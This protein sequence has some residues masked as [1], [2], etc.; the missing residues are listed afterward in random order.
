MRRDSPVT[1]RAMTLPFASFARGAAAVLLLALAACSAPATQQRFPELTY[2]HHG[3]INLDVARIEFNNAYLPPL[4]AP[5]VEHLAP[6][7][8][9]L[10]MERW[11]RD[12]LR[13]TGVTGEAR[14]VLRDAKIVE[15]KLAVQGGVKGMFTTDQGYRYDCSI[16]VEIQIRDANNVQRGFAKAQ[17]AR[18]R[19]V[20]E[21]ATLAEKDKV[22]FDLVEAT[23]T[24]I[25][26]EFEKQIRQYLA[27]YVR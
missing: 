9:S 18:S 4:R 12:R 6:A 23:M 25:N 8:P 14:V 1:E 10:V 22:L 7:N 20:A 13:A 19:T 17:A 2:G 5:N 11:V 16:E 3:V 27:N 21:D 15:S 24:E 26:T